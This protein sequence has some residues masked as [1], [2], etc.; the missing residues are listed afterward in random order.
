MVVVLHK[1]RTKWGVYQGWARIIEW[2]ES[3]IRFITFLNQVIQIQIHF[4][5]KSNDSKRFR[6]R[7][8]NKKIHS[9]EV[10]FWIIS[11]IQIFE[12]VV[13]SLALPLC[14]YLLMKINDYFIIDFFQNINLNNFSISLDQGQK[15]L[16][17][18]QVLTLLVFAVT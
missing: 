8:F 18:V 1:Y 14:N 7:L 12:F 4:F 10:K 13:S 3:L 6:F 5:Q 11:E 15:S 9:S 2:F 17:Y 16:L